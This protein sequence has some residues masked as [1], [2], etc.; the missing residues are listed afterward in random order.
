MAELVGEAG[1]M[2]RH[3]LRVASGTAPLSG[4]DLRAWDQSICTSGEEYRCEKSIPSGTKLLLCTH[5]DGT[6]ERTTT[7]GDGG[8]SDGGANDGASDA[9]VA[10]SP[11]LEM[12]LKRQYRS[13]AKDCKHQD[14]SSHKPHDLPIPP[15]GH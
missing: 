14:S 5:Y 13:T 3:L 7:S 6:I 8:A 1:N 12:A 10:S 9:G 11:P 15:P 4:D 2:A